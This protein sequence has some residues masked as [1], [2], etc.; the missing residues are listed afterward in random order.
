MQE[1]KFIDSKKDFDIVETKEWKDRNT[2]MTVIEH[3]PYEDK[4][5]NSLILKKKVTRYGKAQ[6]QVPGMGPMG[7]QFIFPEEYGLTQCF[8]HFE[9]Y[10]EKALNEME[11]EANQ[12]VIIPHGINANALKT[13]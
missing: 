9:E 10:A 11:K 6:I 5:I 1:I 3:I 7:F 2:G 13:K 12:K 4:N 8:E